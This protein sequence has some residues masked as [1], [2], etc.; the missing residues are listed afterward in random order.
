MWA[1]EHV[2]LCYKLAT[3]IQIIKQMQGNS[4]KVHL[5]IFMNGIGSFCDFP[6]GFSY[7]LCVELKEG[8]VEIRMHLLF[9]G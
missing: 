2:L 4:T 9:I 5:F 6:W 3:F 1:N 8:V 7:L